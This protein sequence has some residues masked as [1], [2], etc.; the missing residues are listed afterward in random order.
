M[1]MV[2]VEVTAEDIAKGKPMECLNCPVALACMRAGLDDIAVC[3]SSLDSDG[4]IRTPDVVAEF[5]HAFDNG[6]PVHPFTF[7]LE[8]P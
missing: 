6:K 5:I 4:S 2:T 7:N 1:A 3:D 8:I